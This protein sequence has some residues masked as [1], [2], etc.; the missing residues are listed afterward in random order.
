MQT[1]SISVSTLCVPC[2][3]RCRYCLLSWDGKLLGADYDRCQRY[4]EGFWSWLKENR[5]EIS[6]Q[7]YYG[8]AMEHP[9]LT[10][11]IDFARKIGSAGGEFLQLDG[12]KFRH[13]EELI[14]WLQSIQTHGIHAIN[15]TFYGTQEYHDRFAGRKGDFRYML[16]ILEQA[17]ILGLDVSISI[18]ITGENANQ[19]EQLLDT[20]DGFSIQNLRFFVPHREGRGASLEKIRLTTPDLNKLSPRVQSH[21]NKTRYKSEGQWIRDAVFTTPKN[22]M[23]GMSLTPE[24]I[25]FFE[26]LSYADAIAYLEALDDDYYRT[27]PTL[28]QLAQRYGDPN[29]Q[30]IFDQQDLYL[31]YQSQYIQENQ[32]K[33]YD[34][35]DE[36]QCFSRR[37]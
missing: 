11:A 35:N 31:Y 7:F 23:L 2:E 34:I 4:A 13:Q 19:M 26:N 9:S 14:K 16:D 24:N 17:N 10:D 32:L 1:T 12:L 18:P 37:F 8:Y 6:F 30:K 22:R 21:I 29:S 3:N 25:A 33:L 27:I 15:L 28:E 20:F 5:P 36:R